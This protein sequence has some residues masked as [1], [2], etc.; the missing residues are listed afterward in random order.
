MQSELDKELESLAA[1]EDELLNIW[2][3]IA[4]ADGGKFY[5]VI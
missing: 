4:N 5:P 3:E 1:F 2:L